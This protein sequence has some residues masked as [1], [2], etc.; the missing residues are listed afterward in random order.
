MIRPYMRW[1]D[2]NTLFR[3]VEIPETFITGRLFGI[4]SCF[5]E[6]VVRTLTDRGKEARLAEGGLFYTPGTIAHYLQSLGSENHKLFV[7]GDGNKCYAP[8]LDSRTEGSEAALRQAYNERVAAD[9]AFIGQADNIAVTLGLNEQVVFSEGDSELLCRQL[10][11]AWVLKKFDEQLSLRIWSVAE[12]KRSLT[13]IRSSVRRLNPR[14]NLLV[15]V[16]PVPLHA[17]FAQRDVR[18]ANMRSKSTLYAALHEFI[19][20]NR[21]VHYFPSFE[22]AQVLGAQ[23]GFWEDD[24]RHVTKQ[25]VDTLMT[26]LANYAGEDGVIVDVK[27]PRS[28][29]D[30]KRSLKKQ[31]RDT[32]RSLRLMS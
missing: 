23:P 25:G 26:Y 10:P 20:D 2:R 32:L 7:I 31:V 12:T 5:A 6:N 29:Y 27:T 30:V 13:S 21:D 18:I 8:E 15:T 9:L 19:D 3:S 11:P 16:S 22:H 24:A 28:S 17:T 14:A 1:R 4:G